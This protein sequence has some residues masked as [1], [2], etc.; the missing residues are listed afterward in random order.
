VSKERSI[1]GR[2]TAWTSPI[3]TGSVC[4]AVAGVAHPSNWSTLA[5]PIADLHGDA[6]LTEVAH[7]QEATRSDVDHHLVPAGMR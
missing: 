7:H 5:D 1:C 3:P 4:A 6:V 2:S